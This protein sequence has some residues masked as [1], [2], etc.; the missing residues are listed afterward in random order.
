MFL[1]VLSQL[2]ADHSLATVLAA[3]V[4]CIVAG[5]LV[6]ALRERAASSNGPTRTQ[7]L[8]GTAIVAGLGV[9]TTHFMAMIGYRPDLPIGY[10]ARITTASA[11]IGILAVGLP[12]AATVLVRRPSVRAV[13]GGT[14][15]LGI[16]AMHYT[17]MLA[18]SGCIQT[19]EAGA[20]IA[21][22]GA[23]ATL[24]ALGSGSRRI[25][26]SPRLTCAT[27]TLAVC[28]AHFVSIAGT[29]LSPL[30]GRIEMPGVNNVL[31][32]FTGMGAAILL[33]GALMTIIA[34]RRF[35]AQERSHSTILSTALHNMSNGLVFIDDSRK[36]GL[37]NDRFVGMFGLDRSMLQVGMKADEVLD[38]VAGAG[39][40][41]LKRRR[42][43]TERVTLRLEGAVL[44][45]SDHVL[46]NGRIVEIDS[47]PVAGGGTVLTFND[48]TDERAA[49]NEISELAFNDPLTGLPNRRTFRE[50]NL[51]AIGGGTPFFLL[52]IDLDRFKAVNDT[53]GH[54]VGDMLLI[55]AGRRVMEVVGESGSAARLGGDEMGVFVYG[56]AN[57]ASTIAQGLVEALSQPF[58]LGEVTLSVGCS[59]GLCS[60]DGVATPDELMQRADL[61]LYEAKRL[62]RGR[63]AC[64]R[65]GLLE[66]AAERHRLEADLRQA[67]PRGQFHLVYQPVMT[68]DSEAIVG[69]EALLRWEHP[70]RGSVPP[71]IF[72]PVAEETGLILDIGRWVLE[73]ACRE[74]AS[75]TN[76]RHVAVNV[77]SVQ[78]R[79]SLLLSHLTTALARSGL[80]ARRLE[81]ELT[82]TAL[83]EDGPR[84][85]RVLAD[86]RLLG[87]KVAM[88][89][90]GTGYSS[91]THLCEFPLDRIKI[92][93]SFVVAAE[94]DP[95]AHAVVKAVVA[96][97]HDIG[98]S[99]L[100]E[101]IETTSQLELLRRLGCGAVQGYLIGKPGRIGIE[102]TPMH[103]GNA[104]AA[105]AP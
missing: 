6:A 58:L 96:L 11:L 46:P 99:T 40:W 5:W 23:G 102:P 88:D 32:I 93:R 44:V 25:A 19:Q 101:G 34:A 48:V 9:W 22:Y 36:L 37:F 62:G 18:L 78:L 21:A 85:A 72:V 98:V 73:E 92:D 82:E 86:V 67:L 55:Q 89:D 17:G 76:E 26:S 57:M 12:L 54:G 65:P 49:R 24:M 7:W 29:T 33:I 1:S 79:S 13:L 77:S 50:R 81:V 51:A 35:E 71:G 100:A 16:G 30:P 105:S 4:I 42:G 20:T 87:V 104:S 53:F 83:V 59:I 63:V 39:G 103:A 41:D 95:H 66:A 43:V 75:W 74:A 80:P 10:G 14:A 52:L 97:G 64:Y 90:F 45:P 8:I 28:G 68:L 94:S 61:A 56:D 60:G 15:G 3:L 2:A 69:Y 91:L 31:S 47:N 70:V 27:F 38:L 84:I